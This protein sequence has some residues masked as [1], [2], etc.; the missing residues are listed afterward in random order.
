VE[1]TAQL[2]EEVIMLILRRSEE[3][4]RLKQEYISCNQDYPHIS[5]MH[6]GVP[7]PPQ[8]DRPSERA[9]MLQCFPLEAT[10]PHLLMRAAKKTAATK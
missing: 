2:L 10:T 5:S 7:T 6:R 3:I 8:A 9:Q 4:N 1:E